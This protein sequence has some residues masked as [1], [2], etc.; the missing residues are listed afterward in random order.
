MS[1]V[2]LFVSFVFKK[3]GFETASLQ[4]ATCTC[5]SLQEHKSAKHKKN[6]YEFSHAKTK[7]KFN[8]YFHDEKLP[9]REDSSKMRK[10]DF[11]DLVFGAG[12]QE[13]A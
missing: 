9:Q 13:L 4:S 6:V 5:A 3:F 8:P 11:H 10:G 7:I 12:A 2:Q 1:C